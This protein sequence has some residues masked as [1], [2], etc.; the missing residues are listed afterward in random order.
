[1]TIGIPAKTK[2]TKTFVKWHNWSLTYLVTK[3]RDK[4]VLDPKDIKWYHEKGT[5]S[6]WLLPFLI[7]FKWNMKHEFW[8]VESKCLKIIVKSFNWIKRYMNQYLDFGGGRGMNY[9]ILC[10]LHYI[11]WIF[12]QYINKCNWTMNLYFSTKITYSLCSTYVL[13]GQSNKWAP[14]PCQG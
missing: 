2:K 8:I 12:V 10:K 1:M 7:F 13:L 6:C 9:W 4:V 11:I 5:N 14:F 3:K